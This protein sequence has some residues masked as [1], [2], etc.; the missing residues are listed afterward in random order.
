MQDCR[1]PRRRRREIRAHAGPRRGAQ[2]ED[3]AVLPRR[4]L[5][6][7]HVAPAV[8]GGLEVLAPGL[9]PLDRAAEP[10]RA[11]HRD[12]VRGVRGDLAAKAAAHLR[13]DHAQ[14][15]LGHPGHDRAQEPEDV[16]VLCGVPHRQLAGGSAPLCQRGP[17]L[18]R[19]RNEPLLDNPF[20]DDD[21]GVPERRVDVAAGHHPVEG[22]VV[23][24]ISVQL[25]RTGSES[26]LRIGHRRQRFVLDLDEI[27]R[28]VR[29]ID[30]LGHDDRDDVADVADRFGADGFVHRDLQVRVRQQPGARDRF[31]RRD[32]PAR[33][34][35]QH[36]GGLP[37]PVGIDPADARVCVRAA[38]HGGVHHAREREVVGIGRG[39]G[40]EA[41]ILTPP[42]PRPEDSGAHFL[43]MTAAASRTARTMFW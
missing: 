24:H 5:D 12:E 43:P 17:R 38:E 13:R 23:R 19:I 7:L 20:L 41:R 37:G 39:S 30:G 35:S 4:E 11:E 22:L 14:L 32:I 26:Q 34:D 28:V 31:E 2:P 10:H 25:R 33:V 36:A 16:G 1:D 6:L 18:H 15:V 29:L 42:D 9:G 8:R 3:G 27:E 21:L 40:D